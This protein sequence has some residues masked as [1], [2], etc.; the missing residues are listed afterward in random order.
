MKEGRMK[1]VTVDETEVLRNRLREV[2]EEQMASAL[3]AILKAWERLKQI[4]GEVYEIFARQI[5]Q[6]EKWQIEKILMSNNERRRK[7]IP[8]VRRRAHLQNIKYSRK[9]RR[10]R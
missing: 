8:M 2:L 1:E 5:S 10:T 3:K 6:I 4:F 9:R 7:G